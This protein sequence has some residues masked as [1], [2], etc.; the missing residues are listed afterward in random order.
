MR[1]SR[2]RHNLEFRTLG[3]WARLFGVGLVK[4]QCVEQKY[5]L[6]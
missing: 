4:R 3:T 1:Y 5:D 2:D 6:A